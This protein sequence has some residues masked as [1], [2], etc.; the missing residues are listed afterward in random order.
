[1]TLVATSAG[2][3]DGNLGQPN[4]EAIGVICEQ[5][6]PV[7]SDEV[8]IFD[9]IKLHYQSQIQ[10]NVVAQDRNPMDADD[11]IIEVE[12]SLYQQEPAIA[13][14]DA[15]GNFNCPYLGGG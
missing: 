9:E 14:K 2:H 13:L 6:R 10:L 5:V 7:S 15:T 4:D 1:M 8:D 11:E 12:L 3:G